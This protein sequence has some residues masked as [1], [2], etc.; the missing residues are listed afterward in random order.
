MMFKALA[1]PSPNS[2]VPKHCVPSHC[3]GSIPLACHVSHI[4]K[5]VTYP[6]T[7]LFPFYLPFN[8]NLKVPFMENHLGTSLSCLLIP[9]VDRVQDS[10]EN[11]SHR[12]WSRLALTNMEVPLERIQACSS[13]KTAQWESIN[14]ITFF[15]SL[16]SLLK[17]DVLRL[18]SLPAANWL[19]KKKKKYEQDLFT[20]FCLFYSL[21]S[22]LSILIL[23]LFL[24]LQLTS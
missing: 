12:V 6:T 18:P 24:K 21:Y 1:L 19:I 7:P 16:I 15:I 10:T 20:K 17:D 4:S 14:N 3:A 11:Y 5:M 22:L 8:T 2:E 23:T 9:R 13:A